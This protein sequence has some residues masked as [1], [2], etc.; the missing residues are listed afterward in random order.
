MQHIA[1]SIGSHYCLTIGPFLHLGIVR[2]LQQL[3]QIIHGQHLREEREA[4]EWMGC[5]E[6]Y[7]KKKIS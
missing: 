6:T 2:F 4:N 3:D 1:L 7:L 5:L